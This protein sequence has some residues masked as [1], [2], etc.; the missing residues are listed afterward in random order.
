VQT[1]R[2]SDRPTSL[3][4]DQVAAN[5]RRDRRASAPNGSGAS[6]RENVILEQPARSGK[7]NGDFFH[8]RHSAARDHHFGPRMATACS[9]QVPFH[10]GGESAP[11]CTGCGFVARLVR[12]KP[13][14]PPVEINALVP[15]LSRH[16]SSSQP[17][18]PVAGACFVPASILRPL[19]PPQGTPTVRA[20]RTPR[21]PYAA[22]G[23]L[24]QYECLWAT[25][26]DIYAIA[27]PMS[28]LSRVVIMEAVTARS[29]TDPLGRAACITA[30]V[31]SANPTAAARHFVSWIAPTRLHVGQHFLSAP[32][33]PAC[34][35]VFRGINR[36]ESRSAWG[37]DFS[38]AST[39]HLRP[40]ASRSPRVVGR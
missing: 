37:Y 38:P 17:Q 14:V 31:S 7:V 39:R 36:I 15:P 12:Q 13:C 28:Q 18:Q 20:P 5:L 4:R 10:P 8:T 3:P 11:G 34:F 9:L 2:R 33:A 40:T 29:S 30:Q 22:A 26:R 21:A 24:H 35:R 1:D 16:E 19:T 32:V 27:E 6:R 25:A 23:E